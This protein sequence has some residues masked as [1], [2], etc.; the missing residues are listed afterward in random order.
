MNV[1]IMTGALLPSM[2]GARNLI[3]SLGWA[4]VEKPY[5]HQSSE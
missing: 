5:A 1:I 4:P 3:Q 2:L